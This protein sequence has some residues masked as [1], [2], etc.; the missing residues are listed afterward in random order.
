MCF[1]DTDVFTEEIDLINTLMEE[2]NIK[3]KRDE[4]TKKDLIAWCKNLKKK[5]DE[6]NDSVLCKEF[7]LVEKRICTGTFKL[8]LQHH[9]KISNLYSE[10]AIKKVYSSGKTNE[11]KAFVTYVLA[12]LEALENAK[13]VDFSKHYVVSF[14][15]SLF[16]KSKK[17]QRLFSAINNTLAK[18]TISIMIY[19][20]DYLSNKVLINNYIKEGYSFG[21]I[22]DNTYDYD[23]SGLIIFDYVFI[24]SNSEFYDAI[25]D[26]KDKIKTKIIVIYEVRDGYIFKIL[27]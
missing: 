14:P 20:S 23:A 12:S 24:A 4:E 9:V 17:I 19:Y 25:I 16:E 15:S 10:Y 26:S 3:F 18:K 1:D 8:E 22:I 7:N 5:K 13:N 21:I 6:F 11:D 27:I 2:E